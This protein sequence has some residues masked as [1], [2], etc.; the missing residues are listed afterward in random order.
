M[1]AIEASLSGYG[2]FSGEA[3]RE[4]R[5]FYSVIRV[6]KGPCLQIFIYVDT[7]YK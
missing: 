7:M 6:I 5:S 1:D 4:T 3:V 2:C